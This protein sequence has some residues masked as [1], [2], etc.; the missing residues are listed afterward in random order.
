MTTARV[1]GAGPEAWYSPRI[2]E[3]E[4]NGTALA[5]ASQSVAVP[6]FQAMVAVQHFQPL[7]FPSTG[8]QAVGDLADPA[9]WV[10]SV[11]E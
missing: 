2:A 3:M 7:L 11:P 8:A 4:A 6:D 10:L 9:L 1:L 5:L